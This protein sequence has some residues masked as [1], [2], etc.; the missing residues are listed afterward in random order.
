[1]A[2]GNSSRLLYGCYSRSSCCA[3]YRHWP[4]YGSGAY[5][6]VAMM[7]LAAGRSVQNHDQLACKREILDL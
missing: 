2:E 5:V 3:Y 6:Y 7:L 4:S 1:M